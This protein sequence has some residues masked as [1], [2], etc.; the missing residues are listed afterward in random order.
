MCCIIDLAKVSDGWGVLNQRWCV[1]APLLGFVEPLFQPGNF[2][3][4]LFLTYI[5]RANGL[6]IAFREKKKEE[7]KLLDH[8]EM[9]TD[10]AMKAAF[11]KAGTAQWVCQIWNRSEHK[12]IHFD[13]KAR[14]KLLSDSCTV[15]C[16]FMHRLKILMNTKQT[17][18]LS[19]LQ[20][21][22][23][24]YIPPSEELAKCDH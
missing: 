18:S 16:V 22:C 9:Q 14:F 19:R 24:T 17:G 13:F 10:T 11:L 21:H 12:N 1:F 7:K 23:L 5:I 15:L 4:L 8:F 6:K 20:H 2:L 3:I